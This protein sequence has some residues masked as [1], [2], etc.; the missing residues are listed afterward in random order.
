MYYKL[1]SLSSFDERSVHSLVQS[2]ILSCPSSP[3]SP[4]SAEVWSDG[5]SW[6]MSFRTCVFLMILSR[7]L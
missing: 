5:D 6:A 3:S 4:S 1:T 7:A 2:D